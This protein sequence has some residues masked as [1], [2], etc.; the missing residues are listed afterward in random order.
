MKRVGVMGMPRKERRFGWGLCS[1]LCILSGASAAQAAG[2]KV[3]VARGM[4][5]EDKGLTGQL[6][7][8]VGVTTGNVQLVQ[9][10]GS[11]VLGYDAGPNHLLLSVS[12]G[13]AEHLRTA[14]SE[15]LGFHGNYRYRVLENLALEA[16][17]NY[18]YDK[19][20]GFDIQFATGP[21]VVFLFEVG[22][23]RV[24]VGLGYMLAYEDYAV[25]AGSTEFEHDTAHRAQLYVF[26]KY[27]L[28]ENLELVEHAFYIPR[29][30]RPGPSDYMLISATSLSIRLNSLLSFQNSFNLSF[31]SP[32]P[33]GTSALNT[34]LMAGLALKF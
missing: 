2:D 13:Y 14:I 3:S 34:E 23:L 16:Y 27:D 8:D 32:P 11:L 10:K 19:F 30:D 24:D 28:A 4:A 17:A 5:E 21:N 15:Q 22:A 31:D 1:A 20:A 9:L 26:L 29:L 18:A 6:N 7:A 33:P 25:S 12:G